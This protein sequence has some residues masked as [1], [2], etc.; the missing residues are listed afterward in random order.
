M[1]ITKRIAVILVCLC[2]AHT[3]MAQT[4]VTLDD[5]IDLLQDDDNA[6]DES[7]QAMVE[8]L[9]HMSEHPTDINRAS[10]EDLLRIPLISDEQAEDILTYIFL[11]KGL[12][13]MAELMAVESLDYVARHAL[14]LFFYAGSEVFEWKDTLTVKRLLREATHEFSTRLDIPLYYREGYNHSPEN[15]GYNGSTLYNRVQYRLRSLDHLQVTFTAEKDQGESFSNGG[16]DHYAGYALL[17]DI[18]HLRTIVVGDYKLGFGEGLVVNNGFSLGKS[19]AFSMQKGI[20]GNTGAD[21]YNFLRGAAGTVQM[22]NVAVS[23]WVSSRKLDATLNDDGDAQ[24]IVTSGLHRTNT[25]IDKRHNLKSF[26]AGGNVTWSTRTAWLGATGYYQHYSL[27]LAPGTSEYRRY[28]P[29]G[30]DFGAMGLNYGFHTRWLT[31]SG[32]TAYST[33]KQGIATLDRIILRASTNCRITVAGRYYQKEYYSFY[34]STLSENSSAQNES[35][36]MIKLD[37]RPLR[38]WTIMAYADFFHNPWPRY[39][40]THSSSGQDFLLLNEWSINT[41]HTLSL[42]YQLKRKESSDSMYTHNKLRLLY[43]FMP[44]GHLRLRST[45]STHTVSH[46]TG[47]ALSEAVR[48]TFTHGSIQGELAYVHSPSYDTRLYINAPQLRGTFSSTALY[49][50]ALRAVVTG[51]YSF[52]ADRITIEARY[53]MLHYFD[54]SVQ[55]SGMQAIDSAWKNDIS[56]QVRIRL[57]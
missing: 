20:R 4:R 46:S 13:S 52:L 11:H 14:P 18:G 37:A 3:A 33:E 23:A 49:G 32:E 28:Y 47:V 30:T 38:F 24:T 35:G 6:D 57:G 51:S 17:K 42:R 5:V 36:A 10:K 8:D 25:E 1:S 40:M 21:E 26:M 15:G 55:S 56:V 7:W 22:G 16:Y 41:R 27:A 19:T 48:Q 43:T 34:A 50:H 45:I 29:E 9:T 39:S 2:L 31:F 44:N 12:R 54:R 53:A